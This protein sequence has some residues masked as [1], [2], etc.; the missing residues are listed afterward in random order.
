MRQVGE[1]KEIL[2]T[3]FSKL[4]Q[5]ETLLPIDDPI[6]PPINGD[7]TESTLL[8]GEDPSSPQLN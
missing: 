5:E 8:N 6:I 7:G 4:P 2:F 1:Y 3:L